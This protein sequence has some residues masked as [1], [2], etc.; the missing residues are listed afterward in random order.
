MAKAVVMKTD[1]GIMLFGS[2]QTVSGVWWN[3]E[4]CYKYCQRSEKWLGALQ[5]HKLVHASTLIGYEKNSE[6][7][8]TKREN[9]ID[10][11][12]PFNCSQTYG[13]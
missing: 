12:I 4:G 10:V 5:S 1:Q 7:W 6:D 9:F 11:E 2:T 8:F 13:G 3:A